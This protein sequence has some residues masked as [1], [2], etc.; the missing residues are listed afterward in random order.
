MNVTPMLLQKTK[1]QT[2][3]VYVRDQGVVTIEIKLVLGSSR[4][5]QSL[6]ATA[7]VKLKA[8]I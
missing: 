5:V 2:C 6:I 3:K 7:N 1:S 8:F 4:L